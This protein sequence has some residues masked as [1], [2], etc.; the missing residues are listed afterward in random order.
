MALRSLLGRAQVVA[1]VERL[2]VTLGGLQTLGGT[3]LGLW[4]EAPRRSARGEA[5]AGL[6]ARFGPGRIFFAAPLRPQA[7]VPEWRF[8][9]RHASER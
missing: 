3:Q 1:G 4:D 2:A 6:I 9:L 7:R 5:V 8:G